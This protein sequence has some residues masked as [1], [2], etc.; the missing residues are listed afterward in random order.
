M[1]QNPV[2]VVDI[3][4]SGF[5]IIF[6]VPFSWSVPLSHFFLLFLLLLCI[7]LLLYY[8]ANSYHIRLRGRGRTTNEQMRGIYTQLENNPYDKGW[9]ENYRALCCTGGQTESL[10]PD[11][12]TL[13]T[14]RD[15]VLEH[16]DGTRYPEI[17]EK[18]DYNQYYQSVS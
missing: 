13:C 17:Y 3:I 18:Y 8:Y 1:V 11:L 16:I 6:M 9:Y 14:V 7:T 5:A 12:T 2:A 15:F 4:L 10:V